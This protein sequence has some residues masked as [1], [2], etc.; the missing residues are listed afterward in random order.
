[1]KVQ[2]MPQGNLFVTIPRQLALAMQ[3][4][5]GTELQFEVNQK[6]NLVLKKVD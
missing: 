4:K 1:M 5:K 3:I 2:Q 6:G